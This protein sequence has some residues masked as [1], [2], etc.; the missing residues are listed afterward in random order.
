M[1]ETA[2]EMLDMVLF[3][4]LRQSEAR[5]VSPSGTCREENQAVKKGAM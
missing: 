5:D 3:G 1:F 2:G 4:I